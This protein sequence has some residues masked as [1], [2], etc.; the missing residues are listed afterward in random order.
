MNKILI[1]LAI[2]AVAA[3][4]MGFTGLAATASGLAKIISYCLLTVILA[5]VILNQISLSGRKKQ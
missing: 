4:L 3:A 2:L 1:G 5:L